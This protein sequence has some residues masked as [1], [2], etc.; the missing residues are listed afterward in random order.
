[1]KEQQKSDLTAIIG[2]ACRF[3]GANDY[4]QFWE[5][6]EAGVNSISEIPPQRWEIEKHYSPLPNQPNKT[7]SKWGGLVEG[8]DEF[9]AEFFSISPREAGKVDPQH[10]IM[11]ELSWSCIEDAGYSPSAFSGKDVGVFMGACNYDSIL[12]MNRNQDNVEGHSGTGTWTCMIPNRISSFFNLHGPS[13]PIDTACSSSLVAVHYALKS[14]KES[15]CEMALVGGISVLFTSTTYIQMSQLGML[16]PTG[17]CRTFSSDADGYVRGEGAGVVLLKPLTKAMEDGDRIYGVI[18]GSAINHGGKARTITSPNVY[19]QAQVIRS[20]YTNANVSPNTVS[21][22]E[23]HGTGT[24]LGDPIEVNALKRAYRQ[25][26][27]QYGVEKTDNSYCGIGAVK[28]NIG[29]LEGAAGIAGLIKVLLAMKYKKLPKIVNFKELNPRISLK[30]TP[31]YLIEETQEWERLK[32]ESGEDIPRR[33]G[34]SSFGIGGVNAHIV[35]EESPEVERVGNIEG[36][37]NILSLSAKT[38]TALA[39]LVNSYENYLEAENNDELADICYTA[40]IGRNDFSHRLAFI[41]S[42]KPDLLEKIKQYKQGEEVTGI[43]SGKITSQT[44]TKIAFLFTGQGSQYLQMGRELY[45]TQPTFKEAI[46]KCNEILGKYLEVPLLDVLYPDD[47]TSTLINQTAYTQPAIFALEYALAKLWSSWGIKPDVV[48]GH[49][50]GEYVAAT[51]AGV[52]SLEDGL[53]LIATRGRL[54]QQLPA[55]G[56]MVSVMASES[57]VESVITPYTDKVAIAAI[58]GPQSIVISGAA[59]EVKD[60]ISSLKS[61]GIKAKKLQVSHAFHSPLMEPMLKEWEAVASQL[62]YNQPKI[63]VVSNV[64]GKVAD[65]SITTTKYWVDHVRQPVRFF[66]GMEV[67]HQ[68]GYDIFLEIGPKPILLGMGRRCLPDHLGEWL[69]SLRPNADEWQQILS[70]LGKLY[71]KG[72][73]VDWLGFEQDYSRKK[74]SLPTYPFQRRRYWVEESSQQKQRSPR[75]FGSQVPI[76]PLLGYKIDIAGQQK[77]FESFLGAE[78]PEYLKDHKVFAEPLLP[79]TAYLEMALAAGKSQYQTPLIEVKELSI[80]RG[81]VLSEAEKI[82]QT[83]L[84]PL[85]N[86]IYQFQIFSQQQEGEENQKWLLHA[87]GKIQPGAPEVKETKFETEK[88]LAECSESVEVAKHYQSSEEM[89]ISYGPSFQR[90]KQLWKGDSQAIAKIILAPEMAATI[91]EYNIHPVMLDSALQVIFNALPVEDNDSQQTYLPVG[92]DKLTIYNPAESSMYAYGSVDGA[93]AGNWKAD[94]ILGNESGKIVAKIS[95]LRVKAASKEALIGKKEESITNLLYE[96]EW[97]AK[98][99]LGRTLPPDYLLAPKDIEQQLEPTIKE[100]I[101]QAQLESYQEVPGKLEALSLDYV[102][103]AIKELGWN[104]QAGD[105][106]D[107]EKELESLGIVEIQQRLFKRM[108]QMMAEG[109]IIEPVAGTD[110]QWNVLQTLDVEPK[111]GKKRGDELLSQYPEAGAELTLLNRCASKLSLV[112]RGETDPVQLVF[113]SGDLSTATRVYQDSTIAKLMNTVVEKAIATAIAQLPKSQSVRLLEIGA[114][115]GGTTSY[116]LPSLPENNT[117]YIFTDLGALFTAKAKER[118]GDYPFVDYQILDIEADP[119]TQGYNAHQY[120]VIIAANVLH[121]TANLTETLSNVRKLLAPGGI[122]VLFELTSRQRWLDLVFGLLEGWW[123]FQDLEIRPDYPLL[124]RSKWQEVLQKTGF[125]EVVSLPEVEGMPEVLYQQSVIV[126]QNTKVLPPSSESK[127]W[128]ILADKQ[129]VAEEL[130]TKLKFMGDVPLLVFAGEKYQ[131]LGEGKFTINPNN[132]EDFK[133]LMGAV[134][135]LYGVVQCWTTETGGSE[136]IEEL[137]RYGCGTTLYLVQALVQGGLSQPPRLWLVT[138]GSQP[139]PSSNSLM[140]KVGQSSLWGMGKVISLEHPEFN[141]V[142]I[143]LD[144]ETTIENQ[145]NALFKEIW[146]EDLEDQVGF[147]E[148]YRY[149]ARLVASHHQELPATRGLT[150]PSQ[151]YKLGISEKGSL[152]SLT[153]ETIKRNAPAPGEVEIQVMATGLNFLDLVATLGLVPDEVDG[154]SQKHLREMDRFGGECGGYVVAVGEGVK[155]LEIG[156]EVVAMARGSFSQY[157]T[158]NA[159]YVVP[160]PENITFAEAASIPANFL[161]AYYALHHVAKITKGDRIL[162]HAAAGGTGMAAVQIAQKV[163]AEVFATASPPKWETLKRMGVKYIMNSR[164]VEFADQVMEFTEGKGVDIVLNSLT[165]G[166]FVSKGLS[167][168]TSQGRFVEIGKRGVWTSSQVAEVRPDISYSVVD[169][170]RKSEEEPELINSM[171]QELTADFSNGLLKPPPLKVFP[172]EEVVSAFRYMQQAKHIGKIV[173]TQPKQEPDKPVSFRDDAAYLITGGMG[174]MGLLISRWMIAKGAKKLVLVGRSTPNETVK[175]KLAEL[176]SAGASVIVEKADVSDWEA[177][178]GVMERINNSNTPLAGVMHSVGVLSDGVLQNQTWSSFEKVMSPKVYGSWYLHQLTKDQPLD[179]F[180]LFSSAASLFGS[181]AQ[182]NHSAA[183]AFLDGLAHY[184]RG[185]KLP[186]LSIHWSTV[187]QIGEAAAIGADVR[188][189]KQGVGAITPGQILESLELLMSG[190]AAQDIEVGVVPIDWSAWQ[191]R[192]SKWRFLADWQRSVVEVTATETKLLEQLKESSPEEQEKI[193]VDYLKGKVANIFG[194]TGSETISIE[195][196]LTT[197]GLDSLMAV[198]L[199]N[200][201]QKELG[202]DVPMQTIIEGISISEIVDLVSKQLL[203]EQVSYSNTASQ[204]EEIDE[205]MEEITL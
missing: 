189:A 132:P 6:I 90:I 141:C 18:K 76:H 157:V 58:N 106:F 19:S 37:V 44:T 146:S 30:G 107:S 70:S 20:A 26:Y 11:L 130:A 193:L 186:G 62:T 114:G 134:S 170:L 187:S 139:V 5:N 7:I 49:S 43:C 155:G 205:D 163:G 191:D 113:P 109:G 158:V 81:L 200:L 203:L 42:G 29:H 184:R 188:L 123:R 172:I 201:I 195:E 47:E 142:R 124:S 59:P 12:L 140:A 84:T 93:G 53:K 181:T 150:I 127:N 119:T 82:V 117:E 101:V 2:I 72:V 108:L 160:K 125:T 198:E 129:G 185:M 99:R 31:F 15:E 122:L 3:P 41:T 10:R 16:S 145:A 97:R 154:V 111:Q 13:I 105:S 83:I 153:L 46:D 143:D 164:T 32:N 135:S 71:V 133:Q 65:E 128:L 152:D 138:S 35:L 95:G 21:Y 112:L 118:F 131:D 174:D 78:N 64:T 55:G 120:D 144:S 25:L 91:G 179:F 100:L 86:D 166:D 48:M 17:Q 88:Y 110:T 27:Q 182:A 194:M 54:M 61:E 148:D 75:T 9:D 92:V 202:F 196:S 190:K 74:V 34:L 199:R 66:Q 156:D 175:E 104:Y 33:A 177:M 96:I 115:T 68:E 73:E 56:E 63:P 204:T 169:L 159:S 79:T 80:E 14:L 173:V 38:E 126:A 67:L 60:I 102:L 165:S 161:T 121:A 89:G 178:K 22:M 137:S 28:S 4:N 8:I 24:P 180:L 87:A 149:I 50:V 176:E 94:V 183:N 136:K 192:V 57:K 45:N 36:S 77:I 52:F 147:R 116:I 167:V 69:P 23:S 40:N 39:D 171:L 197:M 1:M 51:V 98:G 168:V 103:Q 162:I 151:P 85:E